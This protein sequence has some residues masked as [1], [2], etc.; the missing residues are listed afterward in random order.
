MHGIGPTDRDLAPGEDRTW[1]SV[2]QFEQMLDLAARRDHVRITFDDGNASDLE[3]ALPRLLD[4]GLTAEFFV[5]AG[6]LGEPGR[7]DA[8]GVRELVKAGMPVGSH[9]WAHRDWRRVDESE[10]REEFQEAHRVLGDLVGG[11]VD[12]VAIPFGSYDRR[13]LKRLRHVGVRRVLSSDG[14]PAKP[15][16]WLQPRNSLRHDMDAAW[17]T[18][19]VDGRPGPAQRARRLAARTAKRLRGKP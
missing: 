6:L 15:S 7:L 13:V 2:G 1:V 10:A 18:A 4:R 3:I 5:L 11:P 17:L 8:D 14:G 9:G 16:A 19:V 12:S